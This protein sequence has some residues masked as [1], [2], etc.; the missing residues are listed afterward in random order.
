M[1]TKIFRGLIQVLPNHDRSKLLSAGQIPDHV[2]YAAAP[3]GRMWLAH[4]DGRRAGNKWGRGL[5][6]E[7]MQEFVGW[8]V[9]APQTNTQAN[10]IDSGFC[11]GF[12]H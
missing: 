8:D 7:G 4:W 1:P 6:E 2:Q 12:R 5:R 3:F 9:G 10:K 11:L